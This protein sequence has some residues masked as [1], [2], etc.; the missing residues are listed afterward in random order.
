MSADPATVVYAIEPGLAPA[1][2]VD[3][4]RRSGLDARRPV[5]KPDVI[6][7]MLAHAGIVLCARDGAGRLIGVSRALA[8]FSYCCY[9]SDLA[10]DRAWQGQGIGSELMR[11]TRALAGGEAV[12]LLL[13]SAPDAMAYYPKAGMEKFDNCFGWKRGRG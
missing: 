9:L 8:D 13:L 4:L 7:K 6:A 1:E 11:R 12:T 2:F 10:V 5:D 3:V